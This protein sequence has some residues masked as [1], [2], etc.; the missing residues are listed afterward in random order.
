MHEQQIRLEGAAALQS[1]Q[2]LRFVESNQ[3]AP[4]SFVTAKDAF[5]YSFADIAIDHISFF[6][7][8]E[9]HVYSPDLQPNSSAPLGAACKS[10]PHGAPLERKII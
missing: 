4:G 10:R 6:A 8:E 3:F 5:R 2:N 1:L 7:P 9:Q